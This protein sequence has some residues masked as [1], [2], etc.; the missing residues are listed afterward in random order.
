VS[1]GAAS[2][3]FEERAHAERKLQVLESV[4]LFFGPIFVMGRF[5]LPGVTLSDRIYKICTSLSTG[6][7]ENIRRH[8]RGTR[9]KPRRGAG[10][11]GALRFVCGRRRDATT[12]AG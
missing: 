9:R 1:S 2:E 11:R 7:V 10:F 4:Y 3:S 6:F 5:F 12:R 8:R